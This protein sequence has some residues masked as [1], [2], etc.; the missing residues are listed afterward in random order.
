MQI[1]R[2]AIAAGADDKAVQAKKALLRSL[3]AIN[4][5]LPP[6]TFDFAYVIKTITIIQ[7]KISYH[8]I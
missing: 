7:I 4:L 2:E 1:L 3:Q 5:G 6:R 8:K